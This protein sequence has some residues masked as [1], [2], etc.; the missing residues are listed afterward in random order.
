MA[1]LPTWNRPA[2]NV[3]SLGRT[4]VAIGV[5]VAAVA[6]SSGVWAD[7]AAI[8]WYRYQGARPIRDA[9]LTRI[10]RCEVPSWSGL[11]RVV[12]QDVA[13]PCPDGTV[14]RWM[15]SWRATGR[16]W[17]G[18]AAGP[19]APSAWARA[20][21]GLAL[22]WLGEEPPGGFAVALGD[23][24]AVGERRAVL[25]GVA[26][27]QLPDDWIDPTLRR[28]L[29]WARPGDVSP[30]ELADLL[31]LDWTERPEVRG[32]HA[33]LALAQSGLSE[34]GLATLARA[35]SRSAT[36]VTDAA[37]LREIDR[38]H[39]C[40]GFDTRE[41]AAWIAAQ[42]ERA[43]PPDGGPERT[44]PRIVPYTTLPRPVWDA[45]WQDPDVTRASAAWF[46]ALAA[47][48]AEADGPEA[49]AQRLLG[50]VAAERHAFD[51]G[52]MRAGE[53]G[54]PA[55]VVQARGGAPWTSALAARALGVGAE[56]DVAVSQVGDTSVVI[57]VG[58]DRVQIG[59]CGERF[60]AP[61]AVGP[62]VS[63]ESVLARAAVEGVGG[64]LRAQDPAAAR[65]LARLAIA[66]DP[67]WADGV[68]AVVD[69]VSPVPRGDG[70]RGA[71]LGALAWPAAV[72]TGRWGHAAVEWNL[73]VD[74]TRCPGPLSP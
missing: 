5:A 21:A 56:V 26:A 48:V 22:L 37:V 31:R 58:G 63:D 45:L 4:L 61:R 44:D 28:E 12:A 9:D 7:D 13:V 52:A 40:A 41:C 50:L 46:D 20:R 1:W 11:L 8:A 59:P 74:R 67:A 14:S 17:V 70:A 57:D 60:V 51:P 43:E 72:G 24:R 35:R 53:A 23:A 3:R 36:V 27:G 66:L 39:R 10:A 33:R 18:Y 32:A 49:R 30:A 54:D 69:L 16:V 62:R 34:R 55:W 19:A 71:L 47:W 25:E 6:V 2:L 42:L 64:R 73:D 38:E 68:L 29:M 15:A 65:R